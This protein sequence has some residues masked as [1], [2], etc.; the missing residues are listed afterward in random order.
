MQGGRGEG[1]VCV[2]KINKNAHDLLFQVSND[3]ISGFGL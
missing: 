1:G 3:N 2:K